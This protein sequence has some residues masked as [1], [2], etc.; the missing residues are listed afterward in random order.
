MTTMSDLCH[1]V[2]P[3]AMKTEPQ[4]DILIS[5]YIPEWAGAD[6]PDNGPSQQNKLWGEKGTFANCQ[7]IASKHL[8]PLFLLDVSSQNIQSAAE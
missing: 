1:C 3:E 7:L 8:N 2:E 4:V 6:V 5:N